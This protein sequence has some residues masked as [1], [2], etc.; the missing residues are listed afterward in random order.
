MLRYC[1]VTGVCVSLYCVRLGD[2]K[3]GG[4]TNYIMHTVN[5]ACKDTIVKRLCE[6]MVLSFIFSVVINL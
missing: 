2:C 6:I 5:M 4:A 1:I 3:A